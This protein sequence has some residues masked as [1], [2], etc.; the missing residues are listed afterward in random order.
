MSNGIGGNKGDIHQIWVI[1]GDPTV[2]I[3]AIFAMSC[4]FGGVT[5]CIPNKTETPMLDNGCGW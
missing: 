3:L 2:Q 1:W 5:F 4:S